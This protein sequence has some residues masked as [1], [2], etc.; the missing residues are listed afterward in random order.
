MPDQSIPLSQLSRALQGL[1]AEVPPGWRLTGKGAP[2]YRWLHLQV[3]NGLIPAEQINGRWQIAPANLPV[4][5]EQLGLIT[6]SGGWNRRDAAAAR[7]SRR[8]S[9]VAA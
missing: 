7:A 2:G 3:L 5:A 4:I 6:P 9:A 1:T 8:K